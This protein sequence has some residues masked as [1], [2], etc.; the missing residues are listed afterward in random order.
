MSMKKRTARTT[1]FIYCEGKTEH[2]FVK[3]L[4]DLYLVRG[5][6]QV[7]LK[8][9]TGGD[10]STFI[11]ETLKN[12][13]IRDYDGK[14]I[15]LD[16]DRRSKKERELLAKSAQDD[17]IQLIWQIPCLEG[18]LLKILGDREVENQESFVCKK[19]FKRKYLAGNMILSEPLLKKLLPKGVL[20]A[21]RKSI[22]ELDLLIY[23]IERD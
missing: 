15:L 5:T 6:R 12:A 17:N 21:K 3:H 19:N 22:P 7:T 2:L 8:K 4:K 18:V 23:S 1:V 14:Y 13:T 16:A 11:S 20:D 9:G 10:I